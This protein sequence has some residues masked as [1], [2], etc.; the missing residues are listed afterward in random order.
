[1]MRMV[2][3]S[4][5]IIDQ[6]TNHQTKLDELFNMLEEVLSTGNEKIVI[7]SQW[8]RFTR[9][10]AAELDRLKIGYANL[11]GT[12]ASNKRKDLFDRFNHD[13]SC[14]IF[15]FNRC[16]RSWFKFTDSIVVV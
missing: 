8:E 5:Y 15:S 6:Q 7:F 16:R 10:I 1:M 2:C 4:T 12:I 11:N 13:E 14:R 9:L 3:N